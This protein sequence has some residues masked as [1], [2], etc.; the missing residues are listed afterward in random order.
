MNKHAMTT[1]GEYTVPMLFV[2]EEAALERCD[3]CPQELPLREIIF[4]GKQFLCAKCASAWKSSSREILWL[5]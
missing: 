2:P 4:T 3:L 5:N 1:V